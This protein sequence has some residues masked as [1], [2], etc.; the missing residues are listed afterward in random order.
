[1][2]SD[3]T[4][5]LPSYG[6]QAVMEGVLMRGRRNVAMAVRTPSG[7]I[8]TYQEEL[9]NLYRSKWMKIPFIRGI[10]GL[11]DSL[12]LG[13][14]LLMKSAN[15]SSGEDEQIEGAA[16]TGTVVVSLLLGV[17]I[18]FL[19]PAFLAGLAQKYLG[20]TSWW[21][22]LLEGVFR[23][24]ILV[25]YLAAMG[26]V[27]E[28]QR[29]FAYH[30]AEHKTINAFESGTDLTPEAVARQTLV[31]PR[32]GTSFILTLVLLSVL[33]FS[34]LGPLPLHWRLISRVLMLPL[35]SGIAYEYIRFAANWMD[36]SALVRW[37]VKP[38]LWLQKLTTREPS[39]DMLEVSIKAFN[40]MLEAENNP[41]EV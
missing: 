9:P 39:E 32:C 35:I 15:M 31:H 38:N 30:G 17:G 33:I 36:K 19:L 16:L 29:V 34:L 12:N 41:A 5:R 20:I 24:L 13:T 3:K 7:E 4:L 28:I 27:P 23:L 18:F 21:S 25:I 37:L 22:N 10:I 14:R 1:M 26:R 2:P 8:E 6:G 40:M 11:W